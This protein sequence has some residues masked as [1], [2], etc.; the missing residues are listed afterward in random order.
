MQTVAMCTF[1]HTLTYGVLPSILHCCSLDPC[2]RTFEHA[3]IV[4]ETS[5]TNQNTTPYRHHSN[6]T[7]Q[8]MYLITHQW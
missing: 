2:H 6:N 5:C 8:Q 7:K 3:T 1:P 4:D